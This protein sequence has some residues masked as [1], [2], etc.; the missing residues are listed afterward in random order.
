[1]ELLINKKLLLHEEST[2][3]NQ[4]SIRIERENNEVFHY[5]LE[6]ALVSEPPTLALEKCRDD[7]KG[8]F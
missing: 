1:M 8:C 3:K 6:S 5:H 7:F 2:G 4:V